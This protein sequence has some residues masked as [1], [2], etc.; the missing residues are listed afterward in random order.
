VAEGR[1]EDA[2]LL[3]EERHRAAPDDAATA[4]ALS[5]LRNVAHGEG[6]REP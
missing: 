5:I 2:L 1:F 6:R 4:A 3:Y